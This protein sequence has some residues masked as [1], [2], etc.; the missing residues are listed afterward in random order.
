[1]V[2]VPVMGAVKTRLAAD[3]GPVAAAWFYR[4]TVRAVVGRLAH[5]RRWTTLLAVSPDGALGSRAL[6]GGMARMPQGRGD[7]GARMQ[8]LLDLNAL[9]RPP[10]PVVIVGSD[11]PGITPSHIAVAFRRLRGADAILGPAE[12]GGYWL[13]GLR[14]S[15]RILRPF[16][17]VRW[18]T[19]HALAD[20]R[21]NLAGR[22][23][24]MAARLSDVDDA[25]SWRRLSGK[26]G[27]R[28]LSAL[29]PVLLEPRHD[30]DEVAGPM[31]VVELPLENAVP[32][33]LAG[34]WRA[35]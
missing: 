3:I 2:K 21:A 1:M 32:G 33:I 26:A 9:R 28:V 30:L 23:V 34:T 20:T 13:V 4:H 6:P 5:D 25:A 24:A 14:R 22:P 10:G 31:A 17:G 18:S 19:A 29:A 7:L 27:R 8:R 15:P 12:D 16:A 35:G 11:I